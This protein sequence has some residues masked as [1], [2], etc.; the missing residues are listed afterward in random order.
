MPKPSFFIA[1][2]PKGGT[3]ALQRFLKAH[4]AVF[5]CRPKEPKYFAQDFFR[6]AGGQRTFA[7][8]TEADYLDLFRE[9]QPDQRCGEAST[10]YLYSRVAAQ[11][12]HAFNPSARL[13]FVLREPAD[14]LYSYYLQLRKNPVVEG[15][16]VNDFRKALA[17]EPERKQG[18][19]IPRGCLLPEFLYYSER[20]KYAEQ[21]ERFFACFDRAQ[22]KIIIYDDFKR[23]NEGVY[24]DVLAFLGLDPSFTPVFQAHNKGHVLRSKRLQRVFQRVIFGERWAAPLK[25]MLKRLIPERLRRVLVRRIKKQW[26]SRPK[27]ALDPALAAELKQHYRGEVEKLSTLLGRDLLTLW[28]YAPR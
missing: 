16:R 5:M 25:P 4:P 24:R 12:I 26:L 15:E 18:R 6:E 27:D 9:A 17:L 10:W 3:S 28:G 1:G 2:N 19:K 22:I 23:D 13:I 8:M 20:V 14:F 21:L 7:R 11:A